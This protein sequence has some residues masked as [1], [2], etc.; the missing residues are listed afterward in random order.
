MIGAREKEWWNDETRDDETRRTRF[1]L[2]TS[3]LREYSFL[4]SHEEDLTFSIY[5]SQ[6]GVNPV[7]TLSCLLLRRAVI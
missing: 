1:S 3:S 5:S 4:S 2:D 6:L 7:V